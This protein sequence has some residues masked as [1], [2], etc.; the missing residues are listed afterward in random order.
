MVCAAKEKSYL[1]F[2]SLHPGHIYTS[3]E[4]IEISGNI[5]Q[6]VSSLDTPPPPAEYGAPREQGSQINPNLTTAI[7]RPEL[8]VNPLASNEQGINTGP[9][10][11][12]LAQS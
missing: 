5:A 10:P 1:R 9:T 8:V 6:R 3:W 11:E 2:Q 7:D 4:I 12:A